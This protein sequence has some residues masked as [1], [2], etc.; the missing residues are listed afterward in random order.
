[1]LEVESWRPQ[2]IQKKIHFRNFLAILYIFSI[3]SR[4]ST[5][6]KHCIAES[7]LLLFMN[8]QTWILILLCKAKRKSNFLFFCFQHL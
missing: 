2:H 8:T 4:G 1:M 6:C 7:I 3:L 5:I